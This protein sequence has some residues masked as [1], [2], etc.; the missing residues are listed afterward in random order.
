MAEQDFEGLLQSFLVDLNGDGVPDATVQG[1]PS[2]LAPLP[3]V[4]GT[5]YGPR[6]EEMTA[7]TAEGDL[8]TLWNGPQNRLAGIR[9]PR[10]FTWG[11]VGG[12]ASRLADLGAATQATGGPPGAIVGGIMRGIA[13]APAVAGRVGERV[14]R[15]FSGGQSAADDIARTA[16]G[17]PDEAA[18]GF[19]RGM[20]PGPAPQA[21]AQPM[22]AP[23]APVNALGP[24]RQLTRTRQQPGNNNP[25]GQGDYSYNRLMG[26]SFPDDQFV[27]QPGGYVQANADPGLAMGRHNALVNDWTKIDKRMGARNDARTAQRVDDTMQARRPE[28]MAD[29][30]VQ[31]EL[32]KYRETFARDPMRAIN[33]IEAQTGVPRADLVSAMERAGF[34]LSFMTRDK[35][36]Q[37]QGGQM[38]GYAQPGGKDAF[39]QIQESPVLYRQRSMHT[40][41]RTN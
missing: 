20:S 17:V 13:H 32:P 10:S 1:K 30:V 6:R 40:P 16:A 21:P 39:Q 7:Q 29:A 4:P 12:A 36:M 19:Q 18:A 41:R 35:F 31:A 15:M 14:G 25:I 2:D 26:Q 23:A 11:D 8:F 22:P 9:D 37:R 24:D 5:Q 33:D 27:R 34:D 38:G 3:A 28:A